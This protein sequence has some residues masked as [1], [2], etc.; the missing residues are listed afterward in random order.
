VKDVMV[1]R[2][3][4][5]FSITGC[6]EWARKL[7]GRGCLLAAGGVSGFFECSC[8]R[9]IRFQIFGSVTLIRPAT[10]SLYWDLVSR[11]Q[12]D[13]FDGGIALLSDGL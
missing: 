6:A 2:N 7:W 4:V 10:K 8:C 1:P 13:I 5:L 9:K 11:L 12:F 3:Y